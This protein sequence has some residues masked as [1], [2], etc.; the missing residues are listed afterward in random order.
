MRKE[1]ANLRKVVKTGAQ[2][3]LEVA[4]DFFDWLD[5]LEPR[6]VTEIISRY[7]HLQAIEAKSTTVLVQWTKRRQCR[8]ESRSERGSYQGP[9][10]HSAFG[11]S[12]HWTRVMGPCSI[13]QGSG[14]GRLDAA[15]SSEL[16]ISQ[17]GVQ[18]LFKLHTSRLFTLIL[19]LLLFRRDICHHSLLFSHASLRMGE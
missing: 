10:V 13:K 19:R 11:P 14:H 6:S 18:M 8:R 1:R 17:Q 4:M 3:T 5:G 15:A 12:A 7:E 16:H 2:S 9:C